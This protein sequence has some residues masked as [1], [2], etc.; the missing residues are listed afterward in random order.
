MAVDPT[1]G[2]II[3]SA[4]L[5]IAEADEKGVPRN[6]ALGPS[7]TAQERKQIRTAFLAAQGISSPIVEELIDDVAELSLT[8]PKA[9]TI[10]N[11]VGGYFLVPLERVEDGDGDP[12]YYTINYTGT[13]VV[14]ASGSGNVDI[15]F[16]FDELLEAHNLSA[17]VWVTNSTGGFGDAAV[18]RNFSNSTPG[19]VDWSV[20][21]ESGTTF[22][23]INITGRIAPISED[24][25]FDL[26]FT[27]DSLTDTLSGQA[28]GVLT[29]Q[30]TNETFS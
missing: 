2:R 6:Q 17:M 24:F 26:I 13:L 21:Y 19:D 16:D 14:G 10:D 22:V 27:L 18:F 8:Q 12:R 20:P 9:Y 30:L 5:T 1:T 11:G 25:I 7:R 4:S 3:T 28:S 23:N 15:R 29:T